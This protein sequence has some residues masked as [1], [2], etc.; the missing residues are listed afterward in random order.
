MGFCWSVRWVILD[1]FLNWMLLVG[2]VSDGSSSLIVF[3]ELRITV[4]LEL[5]RLLWLLEYLC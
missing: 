4:E 3:W 2:M 5:A 1:C